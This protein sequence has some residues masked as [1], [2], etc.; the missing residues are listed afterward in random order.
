MLR[1]N[2]ILTQSGEEIL[3]EVKCQWCDYPLHIIRCTSLIITT[4]GRATVAHGD[5]V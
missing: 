5:G 3:D 1:L 4:R 2:E